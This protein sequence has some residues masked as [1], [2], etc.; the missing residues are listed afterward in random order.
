MH[1]IIFFSLWF[2]DRLTPV[3]PSPNRRGGVTSLLPYYI[4]TVAA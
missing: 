2:R 4:D 1:S 3:S